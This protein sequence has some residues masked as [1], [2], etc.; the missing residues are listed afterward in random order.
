LTSIAQD[1]EQMAKL[2]VEMANALATG[3][4]AAQRTIL[5][6]RLVVRASTCP[7]SS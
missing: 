5:P 7:L 2:A 3:R 4:P 6:G 1:K